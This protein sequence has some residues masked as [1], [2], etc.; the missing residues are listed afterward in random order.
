MSD[1]CIAT[2][3]A[4]SLTI[5]GHPHCLLHVVCIMQYNVFADGIIVMELSLSCICV[6]C[7]MQYARDPRTAFLLSYYTHD[8][9]Q[10]G[11]KKKE[12]V[13]LGRYGI[14]QLDLYIHHSGL[15]LRIDMHL[16]IVMRIQYGRW[17]HNTG[18]TRNERIKICQGKINTWWARNM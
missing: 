11:K 17:K 7:S 4:S 9:V 3:A 8:S 16:L 15:D 2:V 10:T 13:P 5:T 12:K 14:F 18:V 6:V 1:L